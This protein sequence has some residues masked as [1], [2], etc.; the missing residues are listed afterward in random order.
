MSLTGEELTDEVRALVGREGSTGGAVITD[1][2][3]T[4]WLNEGQEDIA[5]EVLGLNKLQFD[6][7]TLALVTDDI[8]YAIT[9]LTY[10]D[11]TDEGVVDIF[12]V[13]HLDGA[14][15][16]ELDYKPTD[17]FDELLIDPTHSDH[18]GDR[19]TRWTRRGDNIEVAP[20]PSSAYNGDA[21]KVFGQRY[22]REFTTN[23]AS[24][25]ELPN[26]DDGLI[27][28]ATAKA[29]GAIGGPE[30]IAESRR[31]KKMYTNPN[32]PPTEDYGWL[33]DYKD[34]HARMESWSW[35]LYD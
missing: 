25:C 22:P 24:Y 2:R 33:Q 29:W 11:A 30:G 16:I 3:V 10:G 27:F 8:S 28:Y 12:Y 4:R 13:W 5:E 1:V 14:N 21:L 7:T 20:R 35:N 31:Y 15:S 23:D 18:S 32:P 19:P 9:D 17:E 34:K 26:A 6:S